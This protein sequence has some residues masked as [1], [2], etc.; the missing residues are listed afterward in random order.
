MF[1]IFA[2]L[3]VGA[4]DIS[5]GQPPPRPDGPGPDA[6]RNPTETPRPHEA[7]PVVRLIYYAGYEGHV[8]KEVA[9]LHLEDWT[10]QK[11]VVITS[12]WIERSGLPVPGAKSP[13][14]LRNV[15]PFK[16]RYAYV[17]IRRVWE[18]EYA[19]AATE[20]ES[21]LFVNAPGLPRIRAEILDA[22][23]VLAYL[24]VPSSGW[25]QLGQPARAY[26]DFLESGSDA[27]PSE[28]AQAPQPPSEVRSR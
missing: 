7:Y 4:V 24:H 15:D 5:A 17:P 12:R 22:H 3:N 14:G 16:R 13:R 2:T 23:D 10:P 6:T 28:P 11:D 18:V 8:W 25:H 19:D 9:L 26:R 21:H 1:V 20:G 27:P